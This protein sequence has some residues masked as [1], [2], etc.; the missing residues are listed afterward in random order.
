MVLPEEDRA[1]AGQ[2]SLRKRL[3]VLVAMCFGYYSA[4]RLRTRAEGRGAGCR[5]RDGDGGTGEGRLNVQP[6]LFVET[7]ASVSNHTYPMRL[8]RMVGDRCARARGRAG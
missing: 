6:R 3:V 8:S 7:R 5:E 4:F 2:V 1:V